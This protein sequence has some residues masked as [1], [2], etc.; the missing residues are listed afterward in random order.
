M[1][2]NAYH[3]PGVEAGKKAAAAILDIQRKAA[4]RGLDRT[5]DGRPV[6]VAAGVP[7]AAEDVYSIRSTSRR[8]AVAVQRPRPGERLSARCAGQAAIETHRSPVSWTV[9]SSLPLRHT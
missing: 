1:N 5:D 9:Q 2:I 8:T 6:A 7:D 3:Q 4:R